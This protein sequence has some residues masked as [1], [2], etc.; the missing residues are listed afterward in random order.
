MAKNSTA[1]NRTIKRLA[2]EL[3]A[4]QAAPTN[5]EVDEITE[6]PSN[7][8]TDVVETKAVANVANN[9]PVVAT[10]KGLRLV[11]RTNLPWRRKYYYLDPIRYVETESERKQVASQIQLMLKYMAE[12][13]LTNVESARQGSTICAGAIETGYVRT[14]IDPPV[15]FAYYRKDMERLGLVFA[16]YN[17]E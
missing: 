9:E 8:T 10:T 13:G 1:K 7:E 14:K 4:L 11:K 16:G 6:Q 17:I 2:N 12:K 3:A 5:N 15:L